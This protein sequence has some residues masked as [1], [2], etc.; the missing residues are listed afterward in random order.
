MKLITEEVSQVK[1]ITEGKGADK[2][3][4]LSTPI[5]ER[6]KV[7]KG[8]LEEQKSDIF[9]KQLERRIGSLQ[10]HRDCPDQQRL[11]AGNRKAE[12]ERLEQFV[13]FCRKIDL[14]AAECQ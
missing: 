4:F 12:A 7:L 5:Q 14:L 6:I 1:F 10:D 2:K 9:K 13:M 8:Q 11:L 3:T